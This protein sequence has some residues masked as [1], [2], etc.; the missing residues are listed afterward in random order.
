MDSITRSI[1]QPPTSTRDRLIAVVLLTVI[2]AS[3]I[4]VVA[5]GSG[6]LSG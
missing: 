4:L 6:L 5:A 3:I 1:P 2:A